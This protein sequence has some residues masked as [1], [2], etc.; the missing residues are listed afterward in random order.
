[1][2]TTSPATIADLIR[3]G[4]RITLAGRSSELRLLRQ[5]TAPAGPVVVYVHGPAGI[6]KT[7]L[8]SAL[9]ACLEEDGVRRLQLAAG[10]VE[11]TPAAILAALGKIV[12]RDIRTVAELAA[13]LAG[14]E[15]VTVIMV[16]D[17]DVA[18]GSLP[19]S[20]RAFL[21]PANTRFVLAGTVAPPPAWSIEYGQHFLDIKLAALPRRA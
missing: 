3:R 11:P 1:M 15:G 2:R 8:M 13:A 12:E 16:D 19:G 21:L 20:G 7:A 5:V 17:I 6:G 4:R 14:V 18:P 10:A 9:D